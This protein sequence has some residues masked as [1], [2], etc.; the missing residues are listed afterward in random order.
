V[1][2]L[3][4]IKLRSISSN[5]GCSPKMTDTSRAKVLG[6]SQTREPSLA[7]SSVVV[8]LALLALGIASASLYF[9]G[10]DL[11]RF[12]QW[13]A[14]YISLF[15]GQLGFYVVACYVVLR[16]TNRLSSAARWATIG[17]VIFFAIG[18][19]ATLVTQ[20]PYLSTDV[21]RYIWDGHVQSEGVNPYRYVPD[22]QELSSLRDDKIF[23]NINREDRQWLS[24][25]PP[26][27]QLVFVAVAR[28]RPMSVTA[29]KAAMS[30]FDLIT[31]IVLMLVLARS[32]LDPARAIVFAW[33]PLVIFE[34]A[35]SGHIEAVYIAFLALALLAWSRE[36]STLTGVALALATL[37]KFYPALLVPLFLVAK[38]GAGPAAQQGNEPARRNFSRLSSRIIHKANLAMLGGFVGATV[39][40]YVP[41]WSAGR[42]VFGFVRGY[43]EEEGFV[44]SG[45][46][47]FVLDSARKL[48]SIP[49][50]VFLVFALACLM[51]VAIWWLLKAKRDAADVARGAIT[52]IGTYLL[53]STPRYAWY[54][55][56]LVPFL[57]LAPRLG[58]F[59]LSCASVL[60]Y[61][62]WYTPLVYPEVPLW[63]GASIYVPTI[64]WL[65]CEKAIGAR[66]N[67]NE[68]VASGPLLR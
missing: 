42:K 65:V 5:C 12:T 47:Y 67:K 2:S 11:H 62:V 51:A 57:C 37:V 56:W 9:W 29:F 19:R 49:T 25:Y 50:S 16:R 8:P 46:R 32:G 10:R 52:L 21:Y 27:A 40:A 3:K 58:W 20:R 31:I 23:P 53:L 39:L 30:S 44:E 1:K 59:Y 24:P 60:L 17:L 54:Y 61:L 45:A 48:V 14:A 63:I 4:E 26:V 18:F 36:K 68:T 64:A 15:V 7:T 6:Q 33:H 55:V 43:F 38:P 34:G 22:S 13:L 41:Y 35:H 28:I 66:R